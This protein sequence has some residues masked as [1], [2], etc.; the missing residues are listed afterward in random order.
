MPVPCSGNHQSAS[1]KLDEVSSS[2]LDFRSTGAYLTGRDALQVLKQFSVA[3]EER[4]WSLK[5]SNVN[6]PSDLLMVLFSTNE[7]TCIPELRHNSYISL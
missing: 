7:P 5:A 4:R 3:V 1:N 6:L 2:K